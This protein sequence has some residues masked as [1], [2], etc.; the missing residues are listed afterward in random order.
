MEF[1]VG[2]ENSICSLVAKATPLTGHDSGGV[3]GTLRLLGD[4]NPEVGGRRTQAIP[5]ARGSDGGGAPDS[6]SRA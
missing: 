5:G 6:A 2:V 3:G 1:Y 4:H